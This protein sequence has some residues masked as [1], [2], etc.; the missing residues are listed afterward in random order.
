MLRRAF[1]TV[2]GSVPWLRA[3]AVEDTEALLARV[4]QR[5]VD[6]PVLRGEFEQRKTVRGFKHALVSR[7]DYLVA[8]DRG[9]IWHTREPFASTLVVTRERL[10]A[11][12]ADG[13]VTTRLDAR[14]EPAL[15]TINEMLFALMAADFKTLME[16][17]RIEGSM[18]SEGWRMTLTPRDAALARWIIGIDIEGDRHLRQASLREAQGDGSVLRF[19][20][21]SVSQSL[22]R[23]EEAKFD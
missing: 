5:L 19:S 3:I 1:V 14:D 2:L 15:R 13:S 11:R 17:F 21:S 20:A 9:V 10:L 7:G 4:R 23:E 18:Q 8:R 12:Q 22:T 16:R 6:A